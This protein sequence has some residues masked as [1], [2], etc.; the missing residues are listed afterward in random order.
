MQMRGLPCYDTPG[1]ADDE[2]EEVDVYLR[3]RQD[4]GGDWSE[5]AADM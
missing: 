3:Y 5:E 2:G 1:V 4:V